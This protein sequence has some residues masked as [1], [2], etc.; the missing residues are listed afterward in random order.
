MIRGIQEGYEKIGQSTTN[1]VPQILTKRFPQIFII[2]IRYAHSMPVAQVNYL[3]PVRLPIVGSLVRGG[4]ES[5]S[6]RALVANQSWQ[7]RAE[8]KL[9]CPATDKDGNALTKGAIF[10]AG[11]L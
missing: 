2:I 7:A 4:R 10:K 11:E 9:W 6:D 8:Q 1:E 5:Y 3:I